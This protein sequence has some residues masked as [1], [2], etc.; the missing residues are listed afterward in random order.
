MMGIAFGANRAQKIGDVLVSESIRSYESLRLGEEIIDRG[1]S[2][3]ASTLLSNRFRNAG[4]WEFKL[5]LRG[6]KGVK[7]WTPKIIHGEILSGEKLFDNA[8]LKAQLMKKFPNAKGGEMEGL[9]IHSACTGKVNNWILVKAVCDYGDGRKKYRKER[10]Q[11]VA[12]E[13]AINLCEHVFNFP[14]AFM[15]INLHSI[16][17][18]SVQECATI[19]LE[20]EPT[21][22][23]VE[24]EILTEM[25]NEAAPQKVDQVVT[26]QK[27]VHTYLSLNDAEKI[28]IS[29][30]LGVFDYGLTKLYPHVRD[31]EIFQRLKKNNLLGTMWKELETLIPSVTNLQHK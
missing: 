6:R 21:K 19:E 22:E 2:A 12:V 9:G 23:E 16:K 25:E 1:G 4:D 26:I 24:K 28:R 30:K 31:K 29:K 17:E 27:I 5:S 8:E 20:N 14:Y 15:D 7:E 3:P 10:N 13:S 11:K 18:N